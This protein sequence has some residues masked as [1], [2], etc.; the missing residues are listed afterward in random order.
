MAAQARKLTLVYST[1]ALHTL[2][3]IWVWNA[4][5]YSV[6]H[7]EKYIEFLLVQT[8]KLASDYLSG[9]AVP[10]RPDLQFIVI[11]RR[12]KGHGH[13]AV[14]EVVADVVHILQFFHTAQDWPNKI[15]QD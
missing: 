14:Y 8:E 9:R 10:N 1:D 11:R 15:K 7:A 5:H 4:E 6:D 2:D 3:A 13:V 12:R